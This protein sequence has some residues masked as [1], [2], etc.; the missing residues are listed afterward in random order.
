MWLFT[1]IG[2][3][4]VFTFIAD[5]LFSILKNKKNLCLFFI[6]LLMGIAF[7]LMG[8]LFYL[9]IKTMLTYLAN[10]IPQFS[11]LASFQP[12]I[13]I[14]FVILIQI[15]LAIYVFYKLKKHFCLPL[16]ETIPNERLKRCLM[17]SF[18]QLLSCGF[19]LGNGFGFWLLT[20]CKEI[21]VNSSLLYLLLVA[22][23]I[24]WFG[25][26]IIFTINFLESIRVLRLSQLYSDP[27]FQERIKVQNA[28][29]FFIVSTKDKQSNSFR[30]DVDLGI[31]NPIEKE[32]NRSVSAIR[33]FSLKYLKNSVNWRK[34]RKP[35]IENSPRNI[36]I[37]VFI[38][39]I[40][41]SLL[42]RPLQRSFFLTQ[43]RFKSIFN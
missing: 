11:M 43:I 18:K 23:V 32:D 25:L 37:I 34:M 14:L 7:L 38:E 8:A 26:E 12:Y 4:D 35:K 10:I 13:L 24:M 36:S 16:I 27:D 41:K 15:F 17:P 21:T 39:N 28:D 40:V 9:S 20:I 31:Y 5:K 29:G 3:I 19:L 6:N 30:L 33:P 2:A 1:L 42:K 22:L